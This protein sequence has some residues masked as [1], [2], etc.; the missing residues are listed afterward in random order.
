MPVIEKPH[1]KRTSRI[2]AA[3]LDFITTRPN[4]V[5]SEKYLA[6]I[7]DTHNDPRLSSKEFFA[8]A[9]SWPPLLREAF[10]DAVRYA[11][12]R[13]HILLTDKTLEKVK[14]LS[15]LVDL[16]LVDSAPDAE[17]SKVILLSVA[18]HGH[19]DAL[20]NPAFI[21]GMC[22]LDNFTIRK[23]VASAI[24]DSGLVKEIA[25][26]KFLNDIRK[27]PRLI[28]FSY[29]W[30][31]G[32]ENNPQTWKNE[33]KPAPVFLTLSQWSKRQNVH[34]NKILY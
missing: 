29:L 12:K 20:T 27:C 28:A 31:L 16:Q 13:Y 25:N 3:A 6:A 7:K 33:P 26:P 23:L 24:R 21:E 9:S 1:P 34:G 17:T 11:D 19:L 14:N 4:W 2:S 5:S 10:L 22:K 8:Y 30:F 15:P 32:S 18:R